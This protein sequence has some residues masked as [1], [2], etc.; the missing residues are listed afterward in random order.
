MDQDCFSVRVR[1]ALPLWGP[2]LTRMPSAHSATLDAEL[3]D[4]VQQHLKLLRLALP[5]S[6]QVQ[7]AENDP[8]G[9]PSPPA[10]PLQAPE[11]AAVLDGELSLSLISDY[12]K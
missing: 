11:G 10:A 9:L 1:G 7:M 8:N 2:T 12:Y 6:V 3:A 5:R 4:A